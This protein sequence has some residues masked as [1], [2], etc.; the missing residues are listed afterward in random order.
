MQTTLENVLVD[1]SLEKSDY[2][3]LSLSHLLELVEEQDPEAMFVYADRLGNGIGVKKNGK[4]AW[5]Y[6]KKA[7]R[8]GHPVALAECFQCG[9]CVREDKGRALQL[10]R[11]SMERGHPIAIHNLA[12]SHQDGNGVARNLSEAFNLYQKS[13][14]LGFSTSLNNL[15]LLYQNGASGPRD[16]NEALRLLHLAVAQGS[17]SGFFNLAQTHHFGHG[18]EVNHT[19]ALHYYRHAQMLGEALAQ[20][21]IVQLSGALTL[22]KTRCSLK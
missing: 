6:V 19:S 21:H 16:P 22:L 7:A 18:V 17:S 2:H 15:A 11:E 4:L 9:K 14:A 5:S 20:H 13:S 3:K 8:Y 12:W 1:S 10:Y